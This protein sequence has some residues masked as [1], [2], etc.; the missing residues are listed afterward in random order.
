MIVKTTRCSS[1]NSNVLRRQE[2]RIDAEL[3]AV[4]LERSEQVAQRQRDADDE[5]QQAFREEDQPRAGSLKRGESCIFRSHADETSRT[6]TRTM[7]LYEYGCRACGARFEEM[8]RT[9]DR[10]T[11]P[12]CRVCGRPETSLCLSAPGFVGTASAAPAP[13]CGSDPGTCCGGVCLN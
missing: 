6:V 11:P 10:L 12:A 1:Q 9:E 8:R 2:R 3:D 5:W 7:P 13:A 4:P